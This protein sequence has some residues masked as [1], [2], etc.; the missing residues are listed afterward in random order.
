MCLGKGCTWEEELWV[1][2]LPK[3]T[4]SCKMGIIISA[5]LM[6]LINAVMPGKA[7]TMR[8]DHHRLIHRGLCLQPPNYVNK[9]VSGTVQAKIDT[10]WP[11]SDSETLHQSLK[12]RHHESLTS[13]AIFKQSIHLS[14]NVF[15]PVFRSWL[16]LIFRIVWFIYISFVNE[17]NFEIIN[18]FSQEISDKNL[19]VIVLF[20]SVY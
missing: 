4:S 12:R 5:Q 2:F 1:W 3:R 8:H 11:P 17:K 10:S 15:Y 20:E 14:L 6:P 13:E 19:G 16:L 7:H 18:Q 9:T